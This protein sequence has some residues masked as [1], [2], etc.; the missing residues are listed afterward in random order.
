MRA[1]AAPMVSHLDPRLMAM[2]DDMRARL[3]CVQAGPTR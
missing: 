3:A 2:L 1:M